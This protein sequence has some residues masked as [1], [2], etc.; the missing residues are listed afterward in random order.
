[1]LTGAL[2]PGIKRFE[3]ETDNC[4]RTTADVKKILAYVSTPPFVFMA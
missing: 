4:P 3:R 2:F 1:M